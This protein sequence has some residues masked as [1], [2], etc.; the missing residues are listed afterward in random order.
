MKRV[1]TIIVIFSCIL[2]CKK[3]QAGPLQPWYPETN[4]NNDPVLGVFESRIPCGSCERL[5]FALAIYKDPQTG[6]PTTYMMSRIYVGNNND[7]VTNH[8]NISISLGTSLDPSHIVYRLVTGAPAEY[9]SFWKVDE[10]LLFIL[11]DSLTPKVGDA[12]YGYV[13]NK[14]R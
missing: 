3:D 7:R 12:G 8:G 9:Q 5:K 11:D 2:S 1:L 10:N 4:E 6:L 14:V 13:L